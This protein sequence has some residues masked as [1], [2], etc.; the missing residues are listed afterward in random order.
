MNMMDRLCIDDLFVFDVVFA[1]SAFERIF[2]PVCNASG[3]TL[4]LR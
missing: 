4:W 3:D 2:D 1:N